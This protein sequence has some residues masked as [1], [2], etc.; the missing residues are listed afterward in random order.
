MI[1]C[2]A[3]A[4]RFGNVLDYVGPNLSSTQLIIY[5]PDGAYGPG[6]P[7][8]AGVK[9][10]V[11]QG[12]IRLM[13]ATVR[14]IATTLGSRDVVTLESTSASPQHAG[15]GRSWSGPLY[16]ATPQLLRTFG[17]SAASI[18]PTAD[19]LSM[20][21]GLATMSHMQ[22]T[23][24]DY[25]SGNG[26]PGGEGLG[27]YP[28]AKAQCLA[29]PKIQQ[30]S[31]LPSG[32]SAPNTVITEYAV[33]QLG[34]KTTT[35]GWLV[36]TAQPLSASQIDDARISAAS[37]DMHIETKSSIPTSA[38]IVN[39]A[40]VV[41]ILLALGILAMT[42]GLIRSETAGDLRVLT[43]VGASSRTRRTITASTAGA[44]ALLSAVIGT[45]GAYIAMIAFSRTSKLDG[46]SSLTSVPVANLLVILVAMPLVAATGAWLFSGRQPSVIFR[47]PNE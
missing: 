38:E 17:I 4:A 45:A 44:L 20:R 33:H 10:T 30:L 27:A 18:E 13:A 43:A 7:G 12:D 26:P 5:T 6:G 3:S 25:F 23:Y 32:T 40:T 24:G 46:L 9:S 42:I 16:V 11:T 21:L 37:N 35:A 15:P 19:I 8:N 14:R 39:W 22:L 36:Q 47:Q 41:G 29:S 31:Q 2:I 1:V 34:L 28:C